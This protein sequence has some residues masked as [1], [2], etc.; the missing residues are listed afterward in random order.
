M[1]TLFAGVFTGFVVVMRI[2]CLYQ[3]MLPCPSSSSEMRLL[4]SFSLSIHNQ[5]TFP[6]IK[7]GMS[8]F[9]GPPKIEKLMKEGYRLL[10]PSQ[11]TPPLSWVLMYDMQRWWVVL[12]LPPP[13]LLSG[14]RPSSRVFLSIFHQQ[15]GRNTYTTLI[16]SVASAAAIL[17]INVGIPYKAYMAN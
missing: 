10:L 6:P 8:L 12:S 16:F 2:S 3:K 9:V 5:Q 7:I 4:F 1:I 15:L 14:I 13:L 11:P 17:V